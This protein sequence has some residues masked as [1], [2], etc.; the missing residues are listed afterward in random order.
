MQTSKRTVLYIYH[1]KKNVDIRSF[2]GP[3]P[4]VL[5]FRL[6]KFESGIKVRVS[7]SIFVMRTMLRYLEKN[8]DKICW[9]SRNDGVLPTGAVLDTLLS[10]IFSQFKAII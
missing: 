5:N 1:K 8:F 7:P 4:T 9:V 3:I 10:G 2:K 6:A